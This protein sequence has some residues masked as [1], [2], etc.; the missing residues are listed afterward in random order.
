MGIASVAACDVSIHV[1]GRV[2]HFGDGE[3]LLRPS[4]GCCAEVCGRAE[5]TNDA[6]RERVGVVRLDEDACLAVGDELRTL[7]EPPASSVPKPAP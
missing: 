2:G 5:R 1:K 3:A 6:L 4:A 7:G